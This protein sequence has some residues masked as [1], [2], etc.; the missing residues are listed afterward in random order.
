MGTIMLL[1]LAMRCTPP[2]IISSVAMVDVY[3]RQGQ[4]S[5]KHWE[6]KLAD[7]RKGLGEFF[8]QIGG[9]VK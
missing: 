9:A 1:T 2:K 8:E 3:K 4:N 5:V 6:D 7:A